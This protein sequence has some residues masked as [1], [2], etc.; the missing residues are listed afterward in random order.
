[1]KPLNESSAIT[2]EESEAEQLQAN[3]QAAFK[4]TAK[5]IEIADFNKRAAVEGGLKREALYTPELFDCDE[6]DLQSAIVLYS[7]LTSVSKLVSNRGNS[8]AASLFN[9]AKR[10]QDSVKHLPNDNGLGAFLVAIGTA[11]N[12]ICS[13]LAG[14]DK[15][16][17]KVF[18]DEGKTKS[19][20][21][22]P[23]AVRKAKLGFKHGLDFSEFNSMSAIEAK[24]KEIA[25]ESEAQSEQDAIE[26]HKK[27][28]EQEHS[29]NGTASI[30][31]KVVPKMYK[32]YIEHINKQMVAIAANGESKDFENFLESSKGKLEK[33]LHHFN[34]HLADIA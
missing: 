14:I 28:V 7:R 31:G 34:L 26:A 15:M 12:Y 4:A 30:D 16:D 29:E 2:R 33:M 20:G 9:A 3:K 22:W 5:V 10:A 8:I 27:Q 6:D 32:E 23:A 13:D 19:K 1:M 21:A 11:Q 25:A 18:S 24:C 17:T